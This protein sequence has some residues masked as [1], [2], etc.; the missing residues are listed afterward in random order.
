MSSIF[1]RTAS[2]A[3]LV[4]GLGA[5]AVDEEAGDELDDVETGQVEQGISACGLWGC[6]YNSS[7]LAGMDWW[8]VK[9]DGGLLDGFRIYRVTHPS[10]FGRKFAL[11]ASRGKLVATTNDGIW[12]SIRLY[13]HMAPLITGLKIDVTGPGG[14]QFSVKIEELDR[15][16]AYWNDK[17]PGLGVSYHM[18]WKMGYS[19]GGDERY[20]FELCSNPPVEGDHG[21]NGF[22]TVVLDGDVVDPGRK[23]FTADRRTDPTADGTFYWGC[24]G[25]AFAKAYLYRK[26]TATDPGWPYLLNSLEEKTAL[27]KMITSDVCGTGKSF[28][29]MGEPVVFRDDVDAEMSFFPVLPAKIE[30]RWDERGATC[31][32]DPRLSDTTNPDALSEWPTEGALWKAIDTECAARGGLPKS[33][34]DLGEEDWGKDFASYFVSGNY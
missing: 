9:E 4:I 15:Q 26:V 13:S 21:M 10:Y 14:S 5:C 32:E 18:K 31:L 19:G 25:H 11:N 12:P 17:Y 6:G 27:I 20:Q 33:C 28:T 8:R 2:V 3:A 7:K 24:A 30:A 29:A 1:V 23:V 16:L 22:H 34:S